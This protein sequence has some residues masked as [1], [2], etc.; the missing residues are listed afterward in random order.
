MMGATLFKWADRL[1]RKSLRW[2]VGVIIAVVICGIVCRYHLFSKDRCIYGYIISLEQPFLV[3]LLPAV[4]VV[5]SVWNPAP[6][7]WLLRLSKM[8]FVI[9][10]VHPL[11]LHAIRVLLFYT[12]YIDKLHQ[13]WLNNL[14]FCCAGCFVA[15]V[16][17]YVIDSAYDVIVKR[18]IFYSKFLAP[19]TS[20]RR[21]SRA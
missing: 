9:Y 21:D 12:G 20:C 5:F 16:A 1:N 18:I 10:L 4:F 19:G 8:S 13:G 11:C 2:G 17:A 6:R 7:N 14:M 15:T 3:V